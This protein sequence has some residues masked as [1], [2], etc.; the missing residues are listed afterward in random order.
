M[1]K[2]SEETIRQVKA[3]DDI[4]QF[5]QNYLPLKR[6]GR[7]YIG[8]CPFHSEKS[9]SFTVSPDKRIYHCFGCHASGDIIN[10]AQE[11]D[12]LT[13]YEAIE[14]I[15]HFA[16]IQVIKE[17]VGPLAKRQTEQKEE[18]L[19]CLSLAVSFFKDE[20]R[21]SPKTNQYL[22]SRTVNE[23]SIEDFDVGYLSNTNALIQFF[24]Q[25][26]IGEEQLIQ[27]NLI[28]RNEQ[29]LF[30]RFQDRL[31][32]PIRD[33]QNRVIAFGGRVLEENSQKAKYVNSE[34][35]FLFNKRKNLYGLHHAKKS[36]K[37]L[38]SCI[39]VE[40]Y[41][42]VI[43]CHQFGFTNTIACMGTALTY[44]QVALIKRL[45]NNV[46]L[47]LDQDEA[48]LTAT[49][50]SYEQ[51]K[52]YGMSVTVV[53]LRKKDPAELLVS[54]G[55]PALDMAL[56]QAV[57]ALVFI[58]NRL[59]QNMSLSRIEEKAKLVNAIIPFLRMEEDDI[60]RQFYAKQ[61]AE[62]LAIQSKLIIEKINNFEYNFSELSSKKIVKKDK[63][64]RIEESL[65]FILASDSTLRHDF[66]QQYV[67]S[68]T[69]SDNKSLLQSI[70]KSNAIDSHLFEHI[71]SDQQGILTRI[72][73]DY[74]GQIKVDSYKKLFSELLSHIIGFRQKNKI[75][76]LKSKIKDL[77]QDGKEDELNRVLNQLLELKKEIK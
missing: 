55:K 37:E 74:S 26:K 57:P 1:Q 31:I 33:F 41:M 2:M 22:V 76:E 34:E 50:K 12:N 47:M 35:Y 6:R 7:N 69:N 16:G 11:I 17:E 67:D 54:D 18:A 75:D 48:G 38:D 28:T 14:V 32:F 71:Q 39:L 27:A 24:A 36:I 21:K 58:F 4:V 8:L 63:I 73:F 46:I 23:K 68:F 45:T 5:I 42:D 44:E 10:F 19:L 61:F 40:G 49:E 53:A 29:G 64:E 65:I 43:M 30:C 59:K 70:I 15:A 52:K 56:L 20:L 62:E 13:F 60:I 51:L 72:L 9:P 77:E 66:S 25:K 3:Y